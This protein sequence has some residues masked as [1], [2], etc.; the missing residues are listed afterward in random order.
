MRGLRRALEGRLSKPAL[1]VRMQPRTMPAKD[2]PVP[3]PTPSLRRRLVPSKLHRLRPLTVSHFPHS[4]S[5]P[6]PATDSESTFALRPVGAVTAF[7]R[8]SD[9]I[10]RR[11]S[12]QRCQS[13]QYSEKTFADVRGKFASLSLR[14]QE[15]MGFVTAGLMNK[16]VADEM[17][18][19]ESTVKVYRASVMRKMG[20]KSWPSSCEWRISWG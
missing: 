3:I 12:K 18:L 19:A 20:A 1:R 17:Q 8:R 4:N 9:Q 13:R 5:R 14:E 15:V 2:Y 16:Q 10:H 6:D 7:A 11:R